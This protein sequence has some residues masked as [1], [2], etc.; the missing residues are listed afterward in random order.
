MG[1]TEDIILI[2]RGRRENMSDKPRRWKAVGVL[3]IGSNYVRMGIYQ[4]GKGGAQRLEL[5]EH[6]LRIATRCSPPAGSA[7]KP[8]AVCPRSCGAI[9]R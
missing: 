8:S 4:A 2:Q 3:D 5:L 1:Y 6:P 9:P 7:W